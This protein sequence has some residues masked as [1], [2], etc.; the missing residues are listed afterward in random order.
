MLDSE[1][2]LSLII[3]YYME[4]YD[5]FLNNLNQE[6]KENFLSLVD[7]IAKV[8]GKYGDEEISIIENNKRELG[9]M[10][11]KGDMNISELVAYFASRELSIKKIVLFEVYNLIISDDVMDRN[12]VKSLTLLETELGIPSKIVNQIEDV[13]EELNEIYSKISDI[14]I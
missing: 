1:P 8:D 14:L 12:E 3:H 9:L 7:Q 4:G 5:M 6:E 10:E 11:I 13:V 2:I